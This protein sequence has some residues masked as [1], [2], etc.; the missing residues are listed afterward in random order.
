MRTTIDS[1]GRLVV[2]KPLRERLGLAGGGEVDLEEHDGVVEI[3]TAARTVSVTRKAGRPVL[4]VD[5][6]VPRLTD[7]ATRELLEQ[8]RR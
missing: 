1:A 3:R 6:E 4:T 8:T 5:S 2:P 7:E